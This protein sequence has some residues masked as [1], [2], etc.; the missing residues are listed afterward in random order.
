MQVRPTVPYPL[1]L[2]ILARTFLHTVDV[3]IADN[4]GKFISR[5]VM[6]PEHEETPSSVRPFLTNRGLNQIAEAVAAG[7]NH[8]VLL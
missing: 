2:R 8:A 1:M 3:V 6:L 5:L 4:A 7:R